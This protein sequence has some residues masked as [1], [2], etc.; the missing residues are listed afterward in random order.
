MQNTLKQHSFNSN[1]SCA[2]TT[3]ILSDIPVEND[4]VQPIRDKDYL[5]DKMNLS[6]QFAVCSLSE[7]G[8]AL[9]SIHHIAGHSF[10]LLK[11]HNKVATVNSVGVINF[12]PTIKIA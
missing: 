9:T 4:L 1:N 10:A 7:F 8:Y 6:Q 11:K 5:W 12:N 2:Y 3:N